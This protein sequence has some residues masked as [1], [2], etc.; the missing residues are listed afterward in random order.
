[1]YSIHKRYYHKNR[2]C[3]YVAEE[4]LVTSSHSSLIYSLT[5][6]CEATGMK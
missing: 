4:W 5:V 3:R 1:M 2:I 6:A